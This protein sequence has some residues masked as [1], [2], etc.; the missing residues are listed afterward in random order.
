MVQLWRIFGQTFGLSFIK[1]CK[2]SPQD[3]RQLAAGLALATEVWS[4]IS[5]QFRPFQNL[6]TRV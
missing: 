6:E 5:R 3:E 2:S 4:S 1:V